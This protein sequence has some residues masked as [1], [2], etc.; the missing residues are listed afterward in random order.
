MEYT[1][2][3]RKFMAQLEDKGELKRIKKE[4][5]EGHEIFCLLWELYEQK[6][7]AVVFENVKGF[8]MP[9]VSNVS[10]SLNRWALSC[11]LPEG[12]SRHEYR[13]LFLKCLDQR[14]W[15]EP[16]LVTE[17]APCQEV[18]LTGDD[19][20]LYKLPVLKWHP[21]DG[22]PYITQ[23]VV[24][25]KDD[26]FGPNA[27]MYR[28]MIHD[29]QSTGLMCNI[30]QD[31]GIH[32]D[33]ARKAGK[34]TLECAVALGCDPAIYEAAVTKIPINANELAFAS[35][36]RG[37]KPV[38]VVKCKTVDIEVPACAEIIL[39]GEITVNETRAEGPFGEWMGY[40]EEEMQLP[41]FKVKCITHRKNPL[42]LMTTEGHMHS[43]GEWIRIIPQIATVTKSCQ[44]RITGFADAWLPEAGRGYTLIVSIKKHYPGWGKQ[45][46]YQA[47]AL[48]YVG[49][50]A[51]VVIIVD[52]DIDP[53]NEEQVMW[54]LSTRVDPAYDVIVTPAIGGYV[55]NPAA[56]ARPERYSK[57]NST[58][59][60]IS[61]KL[62]ID[63]TLKWKE[64][65]QG[66]EAA[67]SVVP[68]K[69]VL[70]QI[71]ANWSEYFPK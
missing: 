56:A 70:D 58:D 66:R 39:E 8:D 17:P 68:Q 50:S 62:G 71:K 32:L 38:E 28:M 19:V 25:T 54:A 26:H 31:I 5:S 45:A 9:I 63:A 64:E 52:D 51:N 46:F 29:K 30:F 7:P 15:A 47:L 67:I 23:T 27:G 18:V 53:S 6:G 61:G 22:G 13:D 48:G 14:G 49:S 3:L 44:G 36:F 41:I 1:Y 37:G 11:G 34:E 24:I 40:F 16:V 65:R 43:E 20:D 21:G 4:V 42:Y 12:L 2:D 35:A 59:I 55:L 60:V 57:T 10:G 33:R 69:D